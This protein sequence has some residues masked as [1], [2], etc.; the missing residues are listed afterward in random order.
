MEIVY[1]EA[2]KSDIETL[3]NLRLEYLISDRG[4]LSEKER[5]Q[6]INQMI[7]YLNRN[8]NES[9]IAVLAEIDGETVSTAYL[10]ISEK[11]ANPSFLTGKI[12]TILN[13][14]T[15]PQFRK[16]GISTKVL[17]KLID[18]AK[19]YNISKLELSATDMGKS[20]Y[21]K[22]GFREKKSKYTSMQLYI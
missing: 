7:N 17:S 18:K 13:V 10:S 16:Q 4:S 15:K 20:L 22:I 1:R 3:I 6:I 2:T 14:Y 8:I 11:P 9:F 21:E 12:G 19:R 5:S